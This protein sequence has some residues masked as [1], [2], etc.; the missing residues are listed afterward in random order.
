[1]SPLLAATVMPAMERS[2]YLKKLLKISSVSLLRRTKVAELRS[3]SASA[4]KKRYD[5]NQHVRASQSLPK[6]GEWLNIC[7]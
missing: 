4:G 5:A 3:C 2:S 1:M 6:L 7:V